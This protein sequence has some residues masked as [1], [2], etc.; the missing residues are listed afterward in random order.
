MGYINFKEEVSVAKTELINRINNNENI[1]N[2]MKKDKSLAKGFSP[3]KDYSYKE[4]ENAFIG[5][6][7]T[8]DEESFLIIRNKDF[9]CAKFIQCKFENVKFIECNFI[10]CIFEKCKFCNSGVVFDKCNFIKDDSNKTPSLNKEDNFSCYFKE[11]K[12][13]AKFLNS[14]VSYA[15]FEQC[16]MKNTNL[17]QS[18]FSNAI[19]IYSE[20][21]M[22]IIK[23]CNLT[24]SKF[25]KTYISDLEFRDINKTKLDEKTFFDKIEVRKKTR[26]EYEGLYTVYETLANKFKENTLN[27]NFGEYYYLCK[28]MQR[29]TLKLIPRI[30]SYLY[31]VTCGYGERPWYALI[32]SLVL[33]FIFA[34]IYLFSGIDLEGDA[35]QYT[36]NTISTISFKDFIMH[37]NET[38]NLSTGAFV[39]VGYN[40]AKPTE[41][42]YTVENIEMIVGAIM[43]GIGVGTVTRKLVR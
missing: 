24:G 41:I 21:K 6:N 38:L 39:G 34:V 11:C 28:T 33:I 5:K 15:I 27:N 14:K 7:A 12:I 2:E 17:E 13:Y 9:V 25:V 8:E 36:V 16:L 37:M 42:S 40:N 31:L 19:I 1:L 30:G 35:I 10:G 23:D 22:V 4:T 18:N 20:L 29:K 43:M 3:D 26:D 32:T